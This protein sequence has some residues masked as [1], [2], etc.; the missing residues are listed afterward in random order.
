MIGRNGAEARREFGP[1]ERRELVRMDLE[2]EAMILC[3]SENALRFRHAEDALLAKDIAEFREALSSDRR[4]HFMA[5]Q[6]HIFIAIVAI[7]RRYFMGAHQCRCQFAGL[8]LVQ[9]SNYTQTF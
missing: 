4:N 6:A 7:L 8:G 3:G 2:F 1:T 9:F 5:K